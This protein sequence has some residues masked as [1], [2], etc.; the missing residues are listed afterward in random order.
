MSQAT[1]SA[2]VPSSAPAATPAPPAA[3]PAPPP[4]ATRGQSATPAQ[5]RRLRVALSAMALILGLLL[6]AQQLND[7]LASA[8]AVSDTEQLVRAQEIKAQLLR[9]DA[10][11]TNAFLIGGLEPAEQRTAYSTALGTVVS[12]IASAATAQS[13]DTE[14][15]TL[16]NAQVARYTGL[17]EQ[18]RANNRQ[19]LP[20][21]AAYLRL[22]SAEL[23]SS[24]IPLIGAV[25]TAN[26]ERSRSSITPTPWLLAL[27]PGLIGAALLWVANRWTARRFHRRVNPGLAGAAAAL[28]IASVLAAWMLYSRDAR[29]TELR[30]GAY[31]DTVQSAQALSAAHDARSYESLRLIDRG[32]KDKWEKPFQTASGVLTEAGTTGWPQFLA[33]HDKVVARDAG[34]DWDGAVQL[35]TATGA[36]TPSAAF[37]TVVSGLGSQNQAAVAQTR[38]ALSQGR[39]WFLLGA[40]GGAVAGLAAALAIWAGLGARLKEYL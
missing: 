36:G 13:A 2:P 19:G 11:A 5:V 28:L 14:V 7:Y 12:D 8:R 3:T 1:Q 4:P 40:A 9:A 24:A 27:V 30:A 15:L 29:I 32:S 20:V 18:A 34:G 23:R 38:D 31:A 39:Q 37:D 6:L 25:I 17:M 35:S 10:L 33:E 22:A 26:E 21:G 16:L